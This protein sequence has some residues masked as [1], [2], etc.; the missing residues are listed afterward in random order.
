MLHK[1]TSGSAQEVEVDKCSM[2]QPQ[3]FTGGSLSQSWKWT[4]SH[5]CP[6]IW[7]VH[8]PSATYPTRG[9]YER[10]SLD[11][12]ANGWKWC[13]YHAAC[14]SK[15]S[16]QSG[17]AHSATS[18]LFSVRSPSCKE[19]NPPLRHALPTRWRGGGGGLSIDPGST[20]STSMRILRAP[21]EQ[22]VRQSGCSNGR[23]A[24]MGGWKVSFWQMETKENQGN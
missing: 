14:L 13:W 18:C 19:E 24:P 17:S 1:E 4:G 6:L 16:N 12:A 8:L 10:V 15:P 22:D 7:C 2:F 21:F 11:N 3:M 23:V 20:L 9:V 5:L